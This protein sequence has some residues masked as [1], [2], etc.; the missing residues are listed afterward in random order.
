M[1]MGIF[2]STHVQLNNFIGCV[3]NVMFSYT[4]GELNIIMDL[5]E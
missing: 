2:V 4:A 3:N 5:L 1:S